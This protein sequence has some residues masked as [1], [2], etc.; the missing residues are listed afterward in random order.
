MKCCERR[1]QIER[2]R[3]Y[4]SNLITGIGAGEV[5][6]RG[7]LRGIDKY[8]YVIATMTLMVFSSWTPQARR[9]VQSSG[10]V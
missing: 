9:D 8:S 3:E 2:V 1:K 7:R 5:G 10:A 4:P 6:F